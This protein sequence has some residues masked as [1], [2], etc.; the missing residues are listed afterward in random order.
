MLRK[1][2]KSAVKGKEK[3]FF[4]EERTLGLS[5][6]FPLILL[7]WHFY[8]INKFLTVKIYEKYSGRERKAVFP[9]GVG[10]RGQHL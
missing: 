4:F 5:L 6:A 7:V 10:L 3:Q 1:G 2:M 8:Y 9:G